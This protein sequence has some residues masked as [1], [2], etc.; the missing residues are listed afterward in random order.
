VPATCEGTGTATG[1]LG[2]GATGTGEIGIGAAATGMGTVTCGGATWTGFGSSADLAVTRDPAIQ[3]LGTGAAATRG[4]VS[5]VTTGRRA[6]LE[7]S[8]WGNMAGIGELAR[9][10]ETTSVIGVSRGFAATGAG[11][12]GEAAGGFMT[13]SSAGLAVAGTTNG[14]CESVGVT[15]YGMGAG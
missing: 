1:V 9:G 7:G 12:A 5:I 10:A 15:T 8:V 2:I 3:V 6:A 11:G 4:R 14:I 13:P